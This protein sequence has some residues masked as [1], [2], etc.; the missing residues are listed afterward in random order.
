MNW[1]QIYFFRKKPLK[2][3]KI[4]GFFS[5]I[6]PQIVQKRWRRSVSSCVFP[7]KNKENNFAPVDFHYG[8]WGNA[9]NNYF[10]WATIYS[11]SSS[12]IKQ[13]RHHCPVKFGPSRKL[14][15]Q[16]YFLHF[17]LSLLSSMRGNV[18][19]NW[20]YCQMP[21]ADLRWRTDVAGNRRPAG[22]KRPRLLLCRLLRHRK[23]IYITGLCYFIFNFLEKKN[24]FFFW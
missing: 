15:I 7:R 1:K 12:S 16:L 5:R 6:S 3:L 20:K 2:I 13:S 11:S 4:W 18:S 19:F 23:K 22:E 24:L 14:G 17:F 10:E 21:I 9:S 8:K